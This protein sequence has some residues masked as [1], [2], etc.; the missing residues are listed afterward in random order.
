MK[1]FL[2][3]AISNVELSGIRTITTL[4]RKTPGCLMLTMGEPDFDTPEEIKNAAKAALDAGLTHYPEGNGLP[5]VLEEISRFEREK[6]G[7]NFTPDEII[8][9][10]GATEALFCA[11]FG[12]IAPGDEIILPTPA[13]GLYEMTIKLCRGIPV[14]MDTSADDFQITEEK[15]SKAI[16]SKTKAIVITS[17]NNPTGSILNEESLEIVRRAAS[18]RNMFVICDEVYRDL[19]YTDGYKSFATS[20][21]ELHDRVIVTQSFSK[22]YAMTGWRAGYL[23]VDAPIR[24]QIQKIHQYTVVSAVSFIQPACVTALHYNPSEMKETYRRRRAYICDRLEKIGLPFHYPEG[25]FYVFPSIAQFGLDSETFCTKMIREAGIAV[26][27]GTC[28]YAD[29]YIRLSY[30]NSDAVIAE[31]MDRIEKFVSTLRA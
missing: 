26:V 22:P 3:P 27:P 7:L 24:E 9:T 25:A 21:P 11:L 14:L 31:A 4:A 12:I 29:G 16:T 1:S 6:H 28:F 13:F 8:L 23:M 20:Y 30:C 2:N 10:N 17:P 19:V 15:L 18:A 5:Y